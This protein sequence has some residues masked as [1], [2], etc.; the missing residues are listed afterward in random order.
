MRCRL[1][2]RAVEKTPAVKAAG[3]TCIAV[4]LAACSVMFGAVDPGIRLVDVTANAGISFKH[5]NGAFGGKY[6]PE[7]LGSGV[8]FLDYDK[9]GWQDILLVN[10]ADWPGHRSQRTTMALYRNKRNGTFADVTRSA[11]LDLEIY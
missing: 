5:N 7:T 9:D 2:R 1:C 3:A 6:L 11:G 4:A 10:G 8:A